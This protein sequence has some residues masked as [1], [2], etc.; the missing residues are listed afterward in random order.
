MEQ[1]QIDETN[2]EDPQTTSSM[3]N[4]IPVKQ[5]SHGWKV[6]QGFAMV[7]LLL[8]KHSSFCLLRKPVML[9]WTKL[10]KLIV[11]KQWNQ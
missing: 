6:L 2:G 11:A 1:E 8:R 7:S 4:I 10:T 9:L 3:D 5:I